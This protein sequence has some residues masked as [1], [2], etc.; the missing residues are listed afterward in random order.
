MDV[1]ERLLRALPPSASEQGLV[2]S[3]GNGKALFD[4]TQLVRLQLKHHFGESLRIVESIAD[5]KSNLDFHSYRRGKAQAE[6]QYSFV[7][8]NP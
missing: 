3:L 8:L 6:R 7:V 5:T 2:T 1:A 4:L